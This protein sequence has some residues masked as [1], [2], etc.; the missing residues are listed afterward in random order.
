MKLRSIALVLTVA[1]VHPPRAYAQSGVYV[2]FDAQQFARTGLFANPPKGSGNADKPWVLG[3][4]Y[5]VYYDITHLPKLGALKTG[6]V[7][8]GID[9][10]GDT[11]RASI[12]GSQIDRQ[13]G[14]FSLRVAT[15]R[16][17]WQTTPF[18]EGGFG[19]GHTRIPFAQHYSNNFIYQ[20][21]IGADRKISR[22][23]DWRVVEVNVGF[24]GNYGAGQFSNSGTIV[25]PLGSAICGYTV[26]TTP[27]AIPCIANPNSQSSN[28]LIT[29]RTGI[30]YRF[31]LHKES[32]DSK[33]SK[34]VK[35]TKKP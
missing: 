7:V 3:P 28:Y 8:V 19:I 15:K 10:R 31:D 2:T 32:A 1:L 18:I 27:V 5:G 29:L 35:D 33:D 34:K 4:S 21:G 23:F 20:F 9:A 25:T 24:L 6:P 17:F 26:G 13:D 30:T 11:Y 12:Y 16:A 22:S 14:L